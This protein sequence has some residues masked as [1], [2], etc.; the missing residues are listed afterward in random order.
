MKL[1]EIFLVLFGGILIALA[2]GILRYKLF[3]K[4]VPKEVKISNGLFIYIVHE[5]DYSNIY[6]T[7]L[8][9]QLTLNKWFGSKA[10]IP[11]YMGVYYDNPRM[12]ENPNLA[13]SALGFIINKEHKF[14]IEEFLAKH[15]NYKSIELSEVDGYGAVLPL[16]N[17]INILIGTIRAYPIIS[18]YVAKNNKTNIK[19]AIE[20]YD[21][22]KKEFTICFPKVSVD[23]LSNLT[24]IPAP[25]YKNMDSKMK[26][27]E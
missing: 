13:R 18:E 23:K 21:Y 10:N 22:N 27:N 9:I 11:P 17:Y 14:E 19:Y 16:Y 12:I 26:K 3:S 20:L 2:L 1:A 5:G 24:G 8:E 15:K 4:I 7:I 6:K 25:K